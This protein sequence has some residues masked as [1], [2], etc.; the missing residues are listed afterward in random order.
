MLKHRLRTALAFT[1]LAFAFPGSASADLG[2]RAG[3]SDGLD[4]LYIGVELETGATF[5]PAEFTPSADLEFAGSNALA[6]NADLRWDLLPIPETGITLYGK[7]GPTLLLKRDNELGISLSL[8][9]DIPMDRGRSLQIEL[10][11][12]FGDLP[13]SKLGAA[14]MFPF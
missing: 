14:V 11:L 9:A 7:A 12:G 3:F 2:V 13:D 1:A 8:G 10:R 5:G 4:D 6:L